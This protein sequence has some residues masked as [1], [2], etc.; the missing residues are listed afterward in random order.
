MNNEWDDQLDLKPARKSDGNEL[1]ALLDKLLAHWPWLVLGTI[2]GLAAAMVYLR[3]TT[4]VYRT[5]ARLL[6]L[7]GNSGGGG[8]GTL[9]AALLRELG[10]SNRSDISNELEVL[11]TFDLMREV[12]D[13]LDAHVVYRF[14]GPLRDTELADPPLKV[15]FPGG[16]DS[17]RQSITLDLFPIDQHTFRLRNETVDQQ[18]AFGQ[19]F[20]IPGFPAMQVH[21]QVSGDMPHEAYQLEIVPLSA[22]TGQYRSLL[23]VSA[24][25]KETS[26]I[27]LAL[28]YSLPQKGEV[29]LR[30]LIDKYIERNLGDKNTIADSTLAFIEDRLRDLRK[31]LN[32]AEDDIQSFRQRGQL[33]DIT[34]QSQLLLSNLNERSQELADAESQLLVLDEL[35][36]YLRD[37]E[38]LR[39]VPASMMGNNPVFNS[40]VQTYNNLLLERERLL[41]SHTEDNPFVKN[42]DGQVQLLREDML[43]NLSTYRG[44]LQVTRNDLIRRNRLLEADIY[45][46]PAIERGFIDLSRQQQIKQELYLFLQQKWEETAIGRS[47]ITA[48][49]RVIDSPR[50]GSVPISPNKNAILGMGL[51]LGLALPIA[52]IYLREVFNTRISGREDI[53]RRSDLPLIALIGHNDKDVP[54]VVTRESRTPIAEQFRALRTNLSFFAPDNTQQSILLTSSMS[55][56]GKSFVSFNLAI[57]V[58]LAGKK[59]VLLELDLRKQLPSGRFGLPGAPGFTNYII[60]PELP[61]AA[62][63]RPSGLHEL[64]D[65]VGS[66]PIPP[67]PSE[68]LL[69]ER[70]DILFAYLKQHYEVLI[71]DAPPI[72]MVTDAQLLG[73]HAN[74]SLYLIREGFTYKTQLEIPNELYRHKKLPAL[75]FVLNDAK[76]KRGFGYGYYNYGYGYTDQETAKKKKWWK[77][78]G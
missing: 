36:N 70:T 3:F 26:I 46:V 73:K 14:K 69:H 2:V 42:I 34:A 50:G 10:I 7:D 5:T 61:P 77:W 23:S 58:A 47:A 20:H 35:E 78:W 54:I 39:L 33:T 66:G 17:V 57:S 76:T 44:Q 51:L 1:L 22:R 71:I 6:V 37:P 67:N 43:N 64:L 8:S 15:V 49:F 38:Q 4:P 59:V 24:N 56:E 32:A 28:N 53:T 75:S 25:S 60:R 72:G 19:T 18:A 29:I 65:V 13:A 16:N 74:M 12:V 11:R 52:V 55:G 62:V 30:T 27:N 63:I 40:L 31:E 9:D 21:R 68:I 41:L 48:N 45:Q